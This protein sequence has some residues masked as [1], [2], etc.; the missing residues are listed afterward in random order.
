M[1]RITITAAQPTNRDRIELLCSFEQSDDGQVWAPLA[2]AP[3]T[4]SLSLSVVI[5]ALRAAGD[6]ADKR[7][8][9]LELVRT[10]ARSLQALQGAVAIEALEGLLPAGWPITVAL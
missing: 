4:L 8:A 3:T 10:E 9:L 6:D 2:G 7:A 1:Y 5:G